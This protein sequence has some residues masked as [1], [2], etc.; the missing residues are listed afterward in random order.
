ME[1]VY[2]VRLF[3]TGAPSEYEVGGVISETDNGAWNHARGRVDR[4]ADEFD[5][6]VS[7]EVEGTDEPAPQSVINGCAV[8]LTGIK[9]KVTEDEMVHEFDADLMSDRW[10]TICSGSHDDETGITAQSLHDDEKVA[11][12]V[13]RASDALD[14]RVDWLEVISPRSF[15]SV[16]DAAEELVGDR[17]TDDE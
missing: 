1:A 13:Q 14:R 3:P 15:D 5:R 11:H 6:F 4:Y 9:F 17:D 8:V 10:Q 16:V 12:A 7:D 2:S